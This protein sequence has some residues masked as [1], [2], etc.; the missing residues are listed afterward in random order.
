MKIFVKNGV[1]SE[2]NLERETAV[3]K[4]ALKPKFAPF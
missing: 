3:S 4:T 1:R 2:K